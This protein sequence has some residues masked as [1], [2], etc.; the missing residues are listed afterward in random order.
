MHHSHRPLIALL[1]PLLI[2]FVA[3]CGGDEGGSTTDDASKSDEPPTAQERA[4]A[5]QDRLAG[6]TATSDTAAGAATS[7][8]GDCLVAAGFASAPPGHGIVAQWTHSDGTVVAQSTDPAQAKTQAA[9]FTS[10]TGT[11]SVFGKGIIIAG[12]GDRANAAIRCAAT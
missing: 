11:A 9:E 7:S 5:S 1:L 3:A 2:V 6:S 12:S 10:G 8:L 4:E